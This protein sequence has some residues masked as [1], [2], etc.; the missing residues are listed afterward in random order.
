[1]VNPE[2]IWL[3]VQPSLYGFNCRLVRRLTACRKVKRWSFQHDPDEACTIETIHNLLRASI[4]SSKPRPHVIAHGISGTIACLFAQEYPELFSSLTLLSVDT[5]NANHWTSHY[6]VMR[7]QLPCSRDNILTHL[8]SK[9]FD[10]DDQRIIATIS[11]LLAKCLDSD[12]VISSLFSNGL[13]GHLQAPKVPTLII[14]GDQDFVVDK[15]SKI[16]WNSKLKLGDHYELVD[17]GRHFFHFHKPESTAKK[18]N[19]F[20]DMIPTSPFPDFT[21]SNS[22]TAR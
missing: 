22:L 7:G 15:A 11:K 18:I 10:I 13:R 21:P 2:I 14:N 17:A 9:L 8:A 1:M 12:F 16:R 4:V 3:D 20:L 19:T 6:H 5:N